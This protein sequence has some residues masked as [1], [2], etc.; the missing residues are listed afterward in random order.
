MQ[1]HHWRHHQHNRKQLSELFS[2]KV[3]AFQEGLQPSLT[4]DRQ[5][6][7]LAMT[8]QVVV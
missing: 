5:I 8:S 4:S 7:L 1:I 2:L 3:A 6:D